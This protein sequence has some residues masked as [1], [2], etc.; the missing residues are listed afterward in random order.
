V[1][2][3]TTERAEEL[4]AQW[5]ISADEDNPAGP[6]Y[7]GGDYAEADIITATFTLTT[8]CSSCTASR[9]VHCC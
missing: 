4:V 6:L 3:A 1:R 9:T 2:A 7:T 8:H 5:R